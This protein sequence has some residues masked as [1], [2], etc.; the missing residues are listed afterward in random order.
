M[1]PLRM[2]EL[3]VDE[4]A[5]SDVQAAYVDLLKLY[6]SVIGWYLDEK[7]RKSRRSKLLRGLAIVLGVTGGVV[8]IVS[9]IFPAIDSRIG[10]IFLAVA[11][12]CGLA[13]RTFGYTAA[14]N[15]FVRLAV[16]ANTLFLGLQM[17]WRQIAVQNSSLEGQ[18]ELLSNYSDRLSSLVLSETIGWSDDLRSSVED[19]AKELNEMKT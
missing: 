18:W 11:G 12:G 7:R 13:D 2:S 19:L 8:P 15:R 6:E 1:N 9:G 17:A 3:P 10:Y 4:G 16:E 5:L 14:W